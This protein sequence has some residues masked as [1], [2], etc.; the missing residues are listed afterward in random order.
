MSLHN[1]SVHGDNYDAH[2]QVKLITTYHTNVSHAYKCQQVFADMQ[3]ICSEKGSTCLACKN[4]N[5]V[6]HSTLMSTA[7]VTNTNELHNAVVACQIKLFSNN[8]EIIS[9]LFFTLDHVWNWN[10]IIAAA[11]G[12]LKLFQNYF[13]DDERVGKYSRAAISRWNNVEIISDKF[14]YA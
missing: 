13:S 6:I 2:H 8:F 4:S 14:P 12:F 10:Q 7:H 9:V 11:E 3:Q 5:C 1:Y